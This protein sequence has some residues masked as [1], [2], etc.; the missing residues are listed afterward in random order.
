MCS[1]E[2]NGAI[3]MGTVRGDV[4]I[5]ASAR[6]ILWFLL[7]GLTPAVAPSSAALEE[8]Q[9]LLEYGCEFFGEGGYRGPG[10]IPLLRPP[11]IKVYRDGA[12]IFRSDGHFSE[13]K[14][15]SKKLKRLE[16]RVTKA[17]LLREA[18]VLQIPGTD[19]L[20]HGGV[21]YFSRF[22]GE[23]RVTVAS[24]VE[25]RA[26]SWKRLVK[27]VKSIQSISNGQRFVPTQAK[28][29]VRKS[30]REGSP[31][32][33]QHILALSDGSLP[34]IVSVHD[35]EI[36]RALFSNHPIRPAWTFSENGVTYELVLL[37]V[38]GW[39]EPYELET[40]LWDLT[41]QG[42]LFN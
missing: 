10:Q 28:I 13:G 25:P 4:R 12:V 37:Q 19:F 40:F 26:A 29:L 11:E 22:E 27:L 18:A 38:P 24:F 21:C 32:P 7:L 30:A 41:K 1:L 35:R 36:L 6:W 14:V 16:S 23:E 42:S 8:K 34:R 2:G 9:A 3:R 39:Y 17:P 31:W 5:L 20:H 15:P 33:Y